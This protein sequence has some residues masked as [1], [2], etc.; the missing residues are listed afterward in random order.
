M[1][2][3]ET[4]IEQ[5]KALL[6]KTAANGCTEAEELAAINKAAAM[7]DAYVITDEELALT[8]EEVAILYKDAPDLADPHGIRWRLTYGVSQFCDVQ[9]F[10]S[11]RE[12]GLKAIGMPSDVQFAMW[13]LDHLADFVFRSANG[14][15]DC[16][17]RAARRASHDH[18]IICPRLH[19]SN[20]RLPSRTDRSIKN[21]TDQQWPRT[22]CRKG[23]RYQIS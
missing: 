12:T 10:R 17:L 2:S 7:R 8:K 19:G 6:S 11:R 23:R 5:I 9:I 20:H 16:R 4:I 22:S 15:F 1:K 3:R 14:I 13:L 21:G 18:P